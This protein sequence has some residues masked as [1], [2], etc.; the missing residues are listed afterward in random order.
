MNPL[1]GGSQLSGCEVFDQLE[2]PRLPQCAVR[3]IEEVRES[4]LKFRFVRGGE[5][6]QQERTE[7]GFF[8]VIGC[9]VCQ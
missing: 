1:L 2:N 3:A 9:V 4:R 8:L 6:L 5:A 7:P